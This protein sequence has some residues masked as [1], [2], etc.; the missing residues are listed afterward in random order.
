MPS[1]CISPT[2]QSWRLFPLRFRL[3]T[4]DMIAGDSPNVARQELEAFFRRREERGTFY[5]AGC[6]AAQL[7]Q[8]GSRTVALAAWLATLEEALVRPG[9]LQ[10]RPH[11]P[12]AACG[13]ARPS[14]G[15]RPQDA[16]AATP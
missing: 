6:L 7:T 5:C 13:Q 4:H 2:V 3:A 10:V 1:V 11:G 15:S 16:E 9:P 12:C 14:L 8:R